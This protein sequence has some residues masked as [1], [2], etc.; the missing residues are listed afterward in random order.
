MANETNIDWD[1][2]DIDEEVSEQDQKTSNSLDNSSPV[3]KFLCEIIESNA[4]EN[5][6][7]EYT[8]YAANLKFS[9]K[10]ALE[11]EMPIF[12][13]KG[14]PIMRNGEPVKKVRA[15]NDAEAEEANAEFQG[16]LLFD[17]VNLAH[18]KEKPGMKKRRLF[19]AKQIG[20][21]S[22]DSVKL[23]SKMWANAAGKYVVIITGW[24]RWTPKSSQADPNPEPRK[25]VKVKYDGYEAA[26]VADQPEED[27]FDDI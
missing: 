16:R 6:M 18:P 21:I 26:S 10:S 1:A 9:I 27:K 15:L 8:C 19:V 22:M 13:D 17:D 12:D 3:G 4:R 23:T 2:V 11:L 5:A 7:K 20:L 24:N 25:N 14:A